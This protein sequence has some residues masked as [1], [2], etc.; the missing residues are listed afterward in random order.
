MAVE[1]AYAAVSWSRSPCWKGFIGLTVSC[2]SALEALL[3]M[4]GMVNVWSS[5]LVYLSGCELELGVRLRVDPQQTSYIP[6]ELRTKSR[7]VN[8]LG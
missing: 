8:D 6:S 5:G 3:S 2:S 1:F 7:V 4:S